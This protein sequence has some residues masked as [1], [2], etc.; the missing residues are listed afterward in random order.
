M[1]NE[2]LVV[3]YQRTGDITVRNQIIE[4]NTRLACKVASKFSDSAWRRGLEVDDLL[5]SAVEGMIEAMK[6]FDAKRGLRFSTYAFIRMHSR[7]R[8]QIEQ[9]MLVR[10]PSA[11]HDEY[12]KQPEGN[13]L[14]PLVGSFVF[15]THY[16]KRLESDGIE[17]SASGPGTNIEFL[18][19]LR[20]LS[21]NAQAVSR[22]LMKGFGRSEIIKQ[23]G[24]SKRGYTRACEEIKKF[25]INRG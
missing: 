22:L 1:N 16:S 17:D 20:V 15:G 23:L 13:N 24:L 9:T 21:S 14:N 12:L 5:S 2:E 7:V 18:D 6:R 19:S 25:L 11:I 10:V 4:Q 3:L 8:R